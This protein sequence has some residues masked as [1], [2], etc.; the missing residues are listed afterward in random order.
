MFFLINFNNYFITTNLHSPSTFKLHLTTMKFVWWVFVFF[1]SEIYTFIKK[2]LSTSLGTYISQ[3]Y[4]K[5]P[6]HL[7]TFVQ[8][9]NILYMNEKCFLIYICIY[10]L[11]ITRIAFKYHHT[12]KAQHTSSKM[13][14]NILL[15][16]FTW[17][18]R[19]LR[20]SYT[21]KPSVCIFLTH[22]KLHSKWK[23]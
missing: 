8:V 13:K 20:L 21:R 6:N 1:L 10:I 3:T 2:L 19:Y 11:Y 9:N 22:Y 5:L 18:M 15:W 17:F 4:K 14:T 16:I 12:L 7:L 23:W